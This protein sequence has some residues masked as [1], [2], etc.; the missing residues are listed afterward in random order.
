MLKPDRRDKITTAI[1]NKVAPT[2]SKSSNDLLLRLDDKKYVKL[3]QRNR[4]TLA[5]KFFFSKTNTNVETYDVQGTVVQRGSTEYLMTN[6]KARVLR[7]L[8]GS[9]YTYSRLGK[10]YFSQ[11]EV[12]FL[13]HVPAIIKK[14]HSTGLGRKFMVPHIAFMQ[15]DLKI[16][17]RLPEAEKKGPTERQSHVVHRNVAHNW[18][19][20]CAVP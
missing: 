4:T 17:S 7:R 3:Q 5:G 14:A 2:R 18:R 12:S 16:S 11:K 20:T 15:E 1:E 19:Q 10:M 6:G 9:D 13:V 8:N